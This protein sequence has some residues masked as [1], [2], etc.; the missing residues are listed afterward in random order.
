[1]KTLSEPKHSDFGSTDKNAIKNGIAYGA[2]RL[3]V[4]FYDR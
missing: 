4:I 1:M 3:E 2:D